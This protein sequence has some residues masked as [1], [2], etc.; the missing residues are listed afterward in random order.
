MLSHTNVFKVVL[1]L[2]VYFYCHV[3]TVLVG[4][5]GYTLTIMVGDHHYIY[6]EQ[7]RRLLAQVLF[8]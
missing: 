5:C 7:Y 1:K 4:L 3:K 6:S 8:V 2:Q